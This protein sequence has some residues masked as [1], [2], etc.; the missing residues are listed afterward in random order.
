MKLFIFIR[1][2]RAILLDSA[3]IIPNYNPEKHFTKAE[4]FF[5]LYDLIIWIYG[6]GQFLW[7]RFFD[8]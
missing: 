5:M 7:K 8:I 6:I 2:E 3:Q 1:A 4:H